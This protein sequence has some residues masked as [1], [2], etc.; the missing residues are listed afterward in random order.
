MI[1]AGIKKIL[2]CDPSEITADLTPALVKALIAKQGIGMVSNVHGESWN[3]EESEAS[4]TPYKNQLNGRTYR[5]DTSMGDITPSFSIGQYDY[6]TKA[7]LLGGTVIKEGTAPN[8]K[9]VGWKRS[10]DKVEIY[11]ALICLTDDNIWF[12]FPK[13]QVVAREANTDKAVAL[14]V[15]GLVNTP[16]DSLV[17]SEYNFDNSAIEAAV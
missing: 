9:A 3:L 2:Y 10:V 13:C 16:D 8:E 11:K 5:H 7:D 4:V 14:A 1:A 12:I 15:K 6:Q 17:S